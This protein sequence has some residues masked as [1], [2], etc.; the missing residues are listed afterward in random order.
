MSF[1]EAAKLQEP[2]TFTFPAIY[3][4]VAVK[5]T[6]S[7]DKGQ[8]SVFIDDVLNAIIKPYE[9]NNTWHVTTGYLDDDDLVQDIGDRIKARYKIFSS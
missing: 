6:V 4:G 9:D 5:I 8:F 3:D 1:Q 2:E 7:K